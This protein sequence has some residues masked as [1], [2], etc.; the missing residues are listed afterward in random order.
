[1]VVLLGAPGSGQ[2]TARRGPAGRGRRAAAVR[3]GRRDGSRPGSAVHR[4]R[5]LWL[6]DPPGAPDL[7][8]ELAAGLRAAGAAVLVVSPVQGLDPRT[9]VLWE[10]CEA[11]GLPRLVVVTQLDRA[12]RRRRRGG[13]GLP[14]GAR[15][16]RAAA[17][18]A[19]ARRRRR[20]GRRPGPAGPRGVRGRRAPGA[21]ARAPAAGRGAARRPARGRAD[22]Q[23]GRG[24]LRPL[25]RRARSRHARCW[26]PSWRPPWRAATCS[27]PSSS[28]RTAVS[29]WP[30]CSTCWSPR[31]RPPRRGRRP[32]RRHAPAAVLPDPAAPVVA[33][34]V[35]GGQPALLRVWSGTLR[36]GDAGAGRRGGAV[37]AYEGE[38]AGPGDLVVGLAGPP[39]DVVCDPSAPVVLEPWAAA[40]RAVPG[41]RAADDGLA[42]RVA[43]DPVARLETDPGPASCCCGRLGAGARGAAAGRA[44]VAAGRRAGGRA[45]GAGPRTGA[46]VV[47]VG[48]AR[49]AGRARR[50]AGERARPRRRGPAR[51]AAAAGRARRAARRRWRGRA[52]TRGRSSGCRGEGGA[53]RVLSGAVPAVR[54]APRDQVVVPRRGPRG[55]SHAR[56]DQLLRR[57]DQVVRAARRAAGG[58]HHELIGCV[59]AAPRT[60]RS[61][62]TA[63]L[64]GR[65]RR[66]AVCGGGRTRGASCT[67]PITR[68]RDQVVVPRRGPLGREHHDLIAGPCPLA[69]AIRSWCRERGR[70]AGAH[71]DLIS[72]VR[73]APRTWRSLA[74]S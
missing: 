67:Q 42:A 7:E 61:L 11:A 59:R 36:P 49:R 46:V 27:R 71:H 32:P 2:S 39:G 50:G 28:R 17:A 60:W 48:R 68:D 74:H 12:G 24:R 22:R 55:W 54:G 52:R 10:R 72:C 37:A 5:R 38:A 40:G 4:G 34:V 51:G 53:A 65:P 9:A 20:G 14:A 21:G 16:R 23:R 73:A 43:L 29:A 13:R 70:T 35:R 25:A 15:R 19:A 66:S 1:M 64:R 30:T 56:P 58:S 69:D 62:P 26:P 47:R 57:R 63:D 33:E 41:R 8:G 6:L 31:S 45:G 18:A 3:P 44:A